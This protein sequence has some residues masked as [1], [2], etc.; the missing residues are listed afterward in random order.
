MDFYNST[1]RLLDIVLDSPKPM[2]LRPLCAKAGPRSFALL[3]E[4]LKYAPTLDKLVRSVNLL[5]N[6]A[7]ILQKRPMPSS[8]ALAMLLVH[9]FLFAQK[10]ISL[11]KQ[12]PV[13]MAIER[14]ATRSV[15]IRI[16]SFAHTNS[17]CSSQTQGR[18]TRSQDSSK[19][20]DC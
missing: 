9:D 4:T 13:R 17:L 15:P 7:D 20:Q 2:L 10:G 11:P 6:E 14:Y 16:L 5:K 3:A 18:L 1:A 19:S 8:R 12:H